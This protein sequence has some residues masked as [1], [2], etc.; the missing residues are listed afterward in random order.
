MSDIDI[1]EVAVVDD[2]RSDVA[3]AMESTNRPPGI[4]SPLSKT[5]S[6]S[7]GGG[8]PKLSPAPHIFEAHRRTSKDDINIRDKDQREPG[9]LSVQQ[10]SLPSLPSAPSTP[11]RTGFPLRGLSLQLPPRD[12]TSPAPQSASVKP[13]PLSPKL[14]HSHSY[15]SPTNILPRRSR[16]LDFSRAATSLHHSTLADQ[17]S[18]DSSPT[19]GSRAMNIPGSRRNGEYGHGPTEHTSNSLWSMMG[20][21]ERMHI[22]SSLGSNTQMLSDS[23]STSDD[24]DFMDEDMDEAFVTT[25]QAS[26]MGAPPGGGGGGLQALQGAPWMPGGGSPAVNSLLSFQQRQR[27]RQRKQSKK[28]IRGPLGL[29]FNS[30]SMAGAMSKSPP[31]NIALSRDMASPHGRRESISWAA[32]QLHISSTG[33]ESDE[34]HNRQLEGVDSPSR[35][36][37][38]RR[39]V[40]RRGNLLVSDRSFIPTHHFLNNT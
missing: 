18:P 40:T 25:P 31:H 26:K 32:N 14:D 13:A 10:Q 33:S 16:G 1:D 20:N 27:Q 2:N 15:A 3:M 6:L 11:I 5:R 36:H 38:I 35:P 34:N 24:D 12:A 9:Q 28:K 21:Q 37:V 22:S 39:A 30:P 4:R 23:S 17:A 8:T 19:I 29:G 7:D